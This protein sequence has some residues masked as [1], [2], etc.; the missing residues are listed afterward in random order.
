[1]PMTELHM[2]PALSRHCGIFFNLNASIFPTCLTK[3]KIYSFSM[4][5]RPHVLCR[6][7]AWLG[8]EFLAV[9]T[10]CGWIKLQWFRQ[11]TSLD[12]FLLLFLS[13]LDRG[14][15]ST[16][17]ETQVKTH[18]HYN[19]ATPCCQTLM[20]CVTP[21]IWCCPCCCVTPCIWCCPCC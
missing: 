15:P 11:E 3:L 10:N 13:L 12:F 5:A 16:T 4:L 18:R 9:L 2:A 19:H 20:L 7:S 6:L 1:M 8:L 17:V 14:E 21:C